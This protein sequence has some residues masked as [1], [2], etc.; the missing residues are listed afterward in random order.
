MATSA[1]ALSYGTLPIPRTRLI[2]RDAEREAARTFLLD[3]AVP[4]LT[5]TGPG[6]VG[7]TRLALAITDDVAGHFA[8]GVVWVD[9]APLTEPALVPATVAAALGVPVPDRSMTDGIIA[10]LRSGHRLLI[11][12]NCEHLLAGAVD[13][14]ATVLAGCPFV[15]MLATSR[16]PLHVSGEHEY[17]VQPLA[18]P[19]RVDMTPGALADVP[20]VRLYVERAAA[21]D[22][23]FHLTESNAA[24]VAAICTR[25]DGLPLAIELA[26]AR[27]KVLPPALLLPRLARQLPLLTGG[28]RDVPARLQTMREAIV[29]SYELLSA[30]EQRLLAHLAVFVGGFTLEAAESVCGNMLVTD[31]AP[32]LPST[33][34]GIAS[35]VDKSLLLWRDATASGRLGML[36]TIREFALEQLAAAGEEDRAG[37]AHAAYFAT[38]DEWLEPNHVAPGER[39]DDRLWAIEAELANFRAALSFL[40][41]AGDGEGVLQLAGSL[42]IFWHH[43]GNLA[44]GRQWLEWALD[45]T[46]EAATACR[47]RAL[48]GYSLILW[49]QGHLA[50]AGPPAY[51]ARRIAQ[52]I[53][54]TELTALSVHLLGLVALGERQWAQA[55]SHM[56]EALALWRL[57]ELPSDAAMA[58]RALAGVAYETGDA[59]ACMQLAEES[60]ALFRALGH[61]SGAAGAL[62]LLA[63]QTHDQGDDAKALGA[64]HEALQLWAGTDAR[65]AA[66]RGPG[67]STASTFP[68]WAGIDDRHLLVQALVGLATI[69]A[70]HARCD[71]AAM[72]LGAADR[73][74]DD[75]VMAARGSLGAKRDEATA[76]VREAL[77]AVRFAALQTAG[78]HL[79]LKDAVVLALTISASR[80]LSGTPTRQLP[81]HGAS[82]LTD[83]QVEVLRLLIA[84]RSDREIAAALFLSRRTVQDHVSH[85]LAKLGVANRTEAAAVAVRDQLV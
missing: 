66:T 5:L 11:L 23:N 71:Q 39:V 82:A 77:G 46:P 58:L 6:G 32:V 38:L 43:R 64:Y 24:A 19:S 63:R 41:N 76:A 45:H 74:W 55:T 26:A 28:P 70:D 84:G 17:P 73:R 4:L 56:T 83:R 37:T 60:L 47:A 2:G 20:S 53:D 31:H 80:P 61:P 10:H 30:D 16:A 1:S 68:R 79:G 48:A 13:L 69:A 62:G 72:L 75:A 49:S 8:D 33:L 85:L 22:P 50:L 42:A 27:S 54:H 78:H 52:A 59:T 7:K 18:L 67:G 81:A 44:E 3:A 57:L 35:L 21:V 15:Q 25:L 9:L 14:L 40:S 51:M 65:W 36:E 12:D 29:W 34:D